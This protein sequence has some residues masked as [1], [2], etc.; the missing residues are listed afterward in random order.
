M[1]V[2]SVHD[3]LLENFVGIWVVIITLGGV[4][5]LGLCSLDITGS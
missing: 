3:R 1:L 2:D 5:P 4:V